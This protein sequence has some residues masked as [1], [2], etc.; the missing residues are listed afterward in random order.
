MMQ[1]CE[2]ASTMSEKRFVRSFPGLVQLHPLAVL[3][4]NHPAVVVLDAPEG[5]CEA[6]LGRHGAMNP[7]GRVR[8]CNG[9]DETG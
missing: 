6:E 9:M 8:G 7:A 4:R 2:H 1:D 3:A 5:V